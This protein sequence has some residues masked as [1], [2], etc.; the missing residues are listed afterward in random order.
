MNLAVTGRAP[1][2]RWAGHIAACLCAVAALAAPVAAA[3]VEFESGQVRPLALAP[4]GSR[5]FAV[6][7]P[8]NRLEIFAVAAGSLTHIGAVPVGMEPVAVAVR[9]DGNQVWVVNHLSD[10]VS[11]VDLTLTPPRVVRTLLVGDE[12][13]DIV[14]AA[15]RAFITTAHRG[16]NTPLQ[17]TIDTVLRA[18][19]TGR[20][21]VWVFDAA[22]QGAALGGTPVAGTPVTLF[23]DTPRA[24]AVSPDGNTVYAAV[25]HSG[26]QT[27]TVSEAAVCDGGSAVP[28]CALDGV[29]M[30]N[31]LAGGFVPG[32]LPAPNQNM[33]GDPGPEVGL[34]VKFDESDGEWKDD[35]GRN[36]TNAVRFSLPDLDVFAIS[37]AGNPPAETASFAHVG[38]VLFNMVAN[39]MSG[40]VY[41][42]N[43]DA[44][45]LTRF[46]GP[47]GG[48][49]TVR[50]HLHEARITVLDGAT[51]T[52][53][54]LNKHI[55]ALPLGYRTVPMTAGIKDD[56]LATPLGMAV[57][58]DGNTLYLAAFGS[59][60][61][62]IFN[63]AQL[64][65]DTFTPSSSDHIVVSGGGPSGLV[66]DELNARLYVFTRFDNSISVI[67][68]TTKAEIDHLPVYNPEP[69]SV[70]NGRHV[71]YDAMLTSSNG[72]A[73]CSSCHIF[74]DFDSLA[75]DLGNPDDI[76]R[77]NPNAPGPVFFGQQF[78]PMKGPMTTQTLRGMAHDGPMHWRGD[79]T[80]GYAAPNIPPDSGSFDEEAAFTAFQ[81]AFD[82]L[83]GRDEGPLTTSDMQAF[84]DF[85]L[86]V[87]LPP[88][89]IRELN[90]D[91]TPDQSLGLGVFTGPVSDLV[92]TCDG[93][94]TLNPSQGF[95]GTG[96]LSTF[97]QETQEF[98]VPHLSNLYQ[99]IGMFG[100]PNVSQIIPGDNGDKGPQVR[101]FGFL[102]DGA[103]DTLFRFHR[104]VV[105]SSL[106]DTQR[107]Q[108][109]SLM[110]AF[111]T[112]LAPIV[113]QQ[114]TLTSGNGGTV[115]AR[116]DLLIESAEDAFTLAGVPGAHECDLIAKGVVDGEERG[117]LYKPATNV[118]Q[119]DRAGETRTTAHCAA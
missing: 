73:S 10:S 64:E 58:S 12:P 30:P 51:V 62:G 43:T 60:K 85:I 108:L 94:H 113:G 54:H 118:F 5:L 66:L 69:P 11:I 97:E 107:L 4:D 49:T 35:V 13:R 38:T 32:G 9:P 56:S 78:H 34:V 92:T 20:A 17:A 21:D 45:N 68:T 112:T 52:P 19:G 79:R 105:F 59:S 77:M 53:H 15:G 31:G 63:T 110:F 65:A 48:G 26:D 86:Q 98:K 87:T 37:A 28:P 88:N 109:E 95:F 76:V 114:I 2:L 100:L 33:D 83:L 103:V 102:H 111:D 23:G 44:N 119:S 55:T 61:V 24:L 14:F 89:P 67:N 117:Y 82:G 1:R 27:T 29:T 91:P 39:P 71:L 50:G 47:G 80:G 25:F 22:N 90:N 40:R 36:W 3:F 46:E 81:V 115:G 72:E 8:D 42:S 6:N 93:C 7:T 84:T 116:I 104:G 106:S 70:V 75:W 96:A 74:G 18:E 41:V 99:K 57:T 16:Q 101:G